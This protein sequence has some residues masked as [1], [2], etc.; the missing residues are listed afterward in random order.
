[1]IN[2]QSAVLITGATSGLGRNSAYRLGASGRTVV[3]HGRR[4]EAVREVVEEIRSNGGN[5][6]PFVA[7]W[8]PRLLRRVRCHG[9][10]P[11]RARLQAPFS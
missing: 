8:A 3:V 5:A 2:D 6:L 11:R 7:A 10:A 4:V 9:A 1:M